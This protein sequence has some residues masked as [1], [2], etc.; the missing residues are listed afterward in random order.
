MQ[1]RSH[2]EEGRFLHHVV[3]ICEGNEF[4]EVDNRAIR[5]HCIFSLYELAGEGHVLTDEAYFALLEHQ[6]LQ[7]ARTSSRRALCVAIVAIMLTMGVAG[8]SFLVPMMYPPTMEID[9]A[10]VTDFK[11]FIEAQDNQ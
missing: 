4:P 2:G 6:E 9:G 11:R 5:H 1:R 10:Q 8:A 7:E 3:E